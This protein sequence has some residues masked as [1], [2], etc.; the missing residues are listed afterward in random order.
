MGM[1]EVLRTLNGKLKNDPKFGQ[2]HPTTAKVKS[3]K[4]SFAR[5]RMPLAKLEAA[6]NFPTDYPYLTQNVGGPIGWGWVVAHN[7]VIYRNNLADEVLTL[8]DVFDD[9]KAS[10]LF[11]KQLPTD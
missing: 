1:Y 11:K 7:T 3:L 8:F 10:L 5:V 9:T 4:I 6:S 2:A